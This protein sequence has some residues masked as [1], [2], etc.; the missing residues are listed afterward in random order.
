MSNDIKSLNKFTKTDYDNLVKEI[1]KHSKLYYTEDSPTLSDYD[2]DELARRLN[3]IE[4]L[5]PEWVSPDSPSLV[6]GG[7][8][9]KTFAKVTHDPLMLSLDNAKDEK[10]FLD[11][12]KRLLK[13]L[14]TSLDDKDITYH[15]ELKYDGLAVELIYEKGQFVSGSTRGDGQTGEEI[16]HN[17]KVVKNIP[18]KLS[19]QFPD[20]LSVRGEVVMPISSFEMLNK[21]LQ[22]A[23]LKVFANPRNAAAG[24]LRQHDSSVSAKRDL[25]FIPYAIGKVE[26][27]G[28]TGK[29]PLF[30]KDGANAKQ[31]Q[32]CEKYF[33][34]IG[35]ETIEQRVT[36]TAENMIEFYN[37]TYENRSV[38]DFD[39][40]GVV[41]KCDDRNLW[42]LAGVT[43]K[44]P[45]YAIAIKF[46]GKTAI[47]QLTNVTL[48]VG[49]SGVITPVADLKPVNIGGVLV[50]RASLHNFREVERLGIKVHDTVEVVRAGDVIPKVERVVSSDADKSVAIKVP[51]KCPS[52]SKK[53]IEEDVYMRCVNETCPGRSAAFLKYFVSKSGLD[54][55]GLGSEWV[56]KLYNLKLVND[57]ADIYSL[58]EAKLDGLPGMGDLLRSNM[59]SSISQ[60][61]VVLFNTFIQ[62]LGIPNVGSRAAEIL[63]KNYHPI[64][65]L[66]SADEESLASL[67]EIGPVISHSLVEYFKKPQN[68]DVIKRLFNTGFTLVYP[69]NDTGDTT[70]DNQS[71]VFTGTLT[72]MT[73]DEASNAVKKLGGRVISSVSKAT[74]FVV[75]GESPGSKK[76]KAE[77]LGVKILQENEFIKLIGDNEK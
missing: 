68:Q 6:V 70:L 64:D 56:E 11:F 23:E 65:E 55:E 32:L 4:Q 71:F 27:S 37:H 33:P 2:Y 15:G 57:I 1:R 12:N 50:Q 36:G 10:E 34:S 58:D 47:T 76:D 40:D 52:C 62:S 66:M 21:N 24:S 41:I 51:K 72:S 35:F 77:K 14:E 49:R 42:P 60:K 30:E 61:K 20:Y 31:S 19:S 75:V 43:A 16:T 22:K 13:I 39:I 29:G 74:G 26:W 38:L 59:L 46:P 7:E 67:H 48:Q 63:C 69:D 17:L 45:R 54:I 44:A 9:V 53:I 73:R 18:L 28:D 25:L 8:I 3:S 5:H